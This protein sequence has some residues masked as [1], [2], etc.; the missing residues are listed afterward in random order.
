ML[1]TVKDPKDVQLPVEIWM[2]IIE[3]IL[4]EHRRPYHYCTPET[5]PQFQMHLVYC[6]RFNDYGKLEAL[7]DWRNVRAVSKLWNHLAR[8]PPYL[9]LSDASDYLPQWTSSI[10]IRENL[11]FSAFL[12]RVIDDSSLTLNINTLAFAGHIADNKVDLLFEKASLFPALKYLAIRRRVCGERF[13]KNIGRVF[14][15]LVALS[16]RTIIDGAI[17]EEPVVLEKLEIL[18]LEGALPPALV[19]P[20]L[21]H[22]YLPKCPNLSN[23]LWRHHG[24]Q[25]ESLLITGATRKWG[26]QIWETFPNVKVFGDRTYR[27]IPSPPDHHPLQHLRIFS[28][29]AESYERTAGM[30]SYF[31]RIS[32]VHI[33]RGCMGDA[34]MHKLLEYCQEKGLDVI[35]ANPLYWKSSLLNKP[36]N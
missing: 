26:A 18:S 27:D 31:P 32:H 15:H 21:K 10:F 6:N 24:H 34:S 19:L 2:V 30:I 35:S 12:Q 9:T 3:I 20:S 36:T 8:G 16:V 1:D 4:D 29:L 22:I 11:D 25:I 23:S 33:T 5:F 7:Y 14:P 17:S 13:W 28:K